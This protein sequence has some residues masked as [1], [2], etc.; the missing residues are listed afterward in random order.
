MTLRLEDLAACFEG[1]IP[2]IICTCAADGTPN[3]SYLS[4]VARL[5]EAHVAL[6]NQFFSKTA[7]NIRENP[8]AALLVVDARSGAQFRLDLL[9]RET[10]HAGPVFDRMAA[11]L[12]AASMQ[13][14]MAEVMR[15]RGVDIYRVLAL[16]PVPGPPE[17]TMPVPEHGDRLSRALAVVEAFAD[18]TELGA[19]VDSA[20]AALDREFGPGAAMLL[21]HDAA[22]GCLVT[23]GSLGYGRRGVGAEVPVGE[24]V[25]GLAARERRSF[26]VADLSRLRRFGAAVE[27]L[28]EQE[29][30]T[31]S[32][33]L[34]ALNGAMSRIAL[35]MVAQGRL[36]GV[37]L[38]ESPQRLAYSSEDEAALTL[39]A[40]HLASAIALAET[41]PAEPAAQATAPLAATEAGGSFTVTHH[42]FDDSVFIDREY[43]IKGVPGRLLMHMLETALRE[44]RRD[45]TN[46]ELRLVEAL[47]L[48]ELKDNLETRLLLLRRRLEDK[49]APL[50]LLRPARGRLRLEIRGN[51][52]LETQRS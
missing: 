41:D 34:P 43:L 20:L 30:R 27:A 17:A 18:A 44:G 50:R 15:L 33:A 4:H 46:R 47:R 11:E 48:P 25:I 37:L 21:L 45:F 13:I 7:A 3:I 38:L 2:S 12:R 52:V 9:Y 29:N 49:G 31:R 23:L 14:G 42:P 22:R 16:R 51:A 28:S 1:V 40:R 8:R 10:L 26:R 19:I 5:D 24:G 32:I 6:S 35:P 36:R 39:V